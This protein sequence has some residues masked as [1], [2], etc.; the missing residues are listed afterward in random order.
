[1]PPPAAKSKDWKN[2]R[3]HFQALDN[4]KSG[5]FCGSHLKELLAPFTHE[6]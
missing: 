1:L 5:K 2:R 4:L 3:N 6:E